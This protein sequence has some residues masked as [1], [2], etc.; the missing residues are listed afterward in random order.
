MFRC[1]GRIFAGAQ[2]IGEMQTSQPCVS[3]AP[4][5]AISIADIDFSIAEQLRDQRGP[6]SLSDITPDRLGTPIN[7]ETELS[8]LKVPPAKRAKSMPRTQIVADIPAPLTFEKD[9]PMI[10]QQ[11]PDDSLIFITQSDH[12]K[13]SG[14][15]AAHWGSD[16]FERPHP[17]ESTVGAAVFHGCGWYPVGCQCGSRMPSASRWVMAPVNVRLVGK[18]LRDAWTNQPP[19]ERIEEEGPSEVEAE[20]IWPR[21]KFTEGLA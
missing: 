20:R 1:T 8:P 7:H 17:Y 9:G 11:Q 19:G 10:V 4:S 3:H 14:I 6:A 12:A 21:P 15:F 2:N 13:L 16:R 18:S 5:E